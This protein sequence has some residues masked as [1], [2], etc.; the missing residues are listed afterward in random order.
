MELTW[1]RPW[2]VARALHRRA[3]RA[4]GRLIDQALGVRTAWL[5]PTAAAAGDAAIATKPCGWLTLYRV[6]HWLDVSDADVLIDLGSGPGRAVLIG[7]LFPFRRAIGVERDP[8]LHRQAL[9]NL[10]TFRLK[11][12]ADVEFVC[13]D[14]LDYTLPDDATVIFLYNP[15]NGVT[16][17]EA[18]AGV[19]RSLDR[20]PR[21]LRI[22]Y[23]N[24]VEHEMLVATGRCR[25]VARLMS[26]LRPGRQWAR[27]LAAY[28][29][30]VAPTAPAPSSRS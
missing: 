29:Y 19:L 3:R 9:A 20:A 15:F 27:T 25:L 14:V 8:I 23:V 26:H 6:F 28:V 17:E 2:P 18:I 5:E 4:I 16:F 10:A 12:R 30:E 22:V 24:P 1:T 21:P 7:S 13:A 11:R